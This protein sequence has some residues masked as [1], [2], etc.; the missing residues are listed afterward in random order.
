MV[1]RQVH[2][3][4]NGQ[5][6][7]CFVFPRTGRPFGRLAIKKDRPTLLEEGEE[8]LAVRQQRFKRPVVETAVV[9]LK[10]DE[11]LIED[12]RDTLALIVTAQ[13]Y[14]QYASQITAAAKSSFLAGDQS[15]YIAGIIAILIGAIVVF[16]VFPK[17][18]E[19]RKVLVEYHQ[20][21]L[22]AMGV[23]SGAEPVVQPAG[24]PED[25][26]LAPNLVKK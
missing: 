5:A 11:S 23:L 22:A 25:H 10:L 14:P 21:D 1:E 24:R 9:T 12:C 20:D 18:D 3:P 16:F 13:Q 17:R 2:G 7:G 19:E 4:S 15:A 26:V 6:V 8:R